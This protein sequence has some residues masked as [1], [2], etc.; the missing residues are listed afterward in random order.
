LRTELGAPEDRRAALAPRRGPRPPARDG[1][2]EECVEVGEPL[3]EPLQLDATVDEEILPELVATVHLEHQPA[4][5]AEPLLARLE[6]C[7]S[8]A[9][10]LA[11]G[12]QCAPNGA[13]R[14]GGRSGCGACGSA[15]NPHPAIL[16]M[17]AAGWADR[18]GPRGGRSRRATGRRARAPRSRPGSRPRG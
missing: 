14:R 5:V 3:L 18:P 7:A 1:G 10:E 12:R 8:L 6:Q 4:E 17:Q 11:G 16:F 15:A 13:R 2:G 9:P